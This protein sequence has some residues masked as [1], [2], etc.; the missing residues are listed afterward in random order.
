LERD[1]SLE[2]AKSGLEYQDQIRKASVAVFGI[3]RLGSQ[4]THLLALAG[5]GKIIVIDAEAVG[6]LEL[7]SDAWFAANEEGRNR[8][9]VIAERV[10]AANPMVAME[11]A[12]EPLQIDELQQLLS[13]IDF[14]VLCRDHFNPHDYEIFNKAAL[15]VKKSWTS[16]RL[17]GFEFQIGPTVIPFQTSCYQ[18]FDMRYKSNLPDIA[19]Y[20]IVED[21]LKN[22]RLRPETLVFTP[23]VGLLALE[24]LKALTWFMAPATYSHLYTLNLLTL[25]SKLHPILKIPRCSACGRL[26]QSRPTIN[27][28]QQSQESL[29]L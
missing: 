26:S 18:C 4:L 6:E 25:E 28:W 27:I 11:I 3:G 9:E 24:V 16:A 29:K 2:V 8:A 1:A 20:Q 15:E 23:G 13:K 12:P 7:Y 14:A 21:F 19:E 10:A 17:A 22:G 5:V